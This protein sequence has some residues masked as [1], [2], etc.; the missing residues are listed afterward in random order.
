MR[1][2]RLG[3]ALVLTLPLTLTACGLLPEE[4]Q[5]PATPIIYDYKPQEYTQVEVLQGDLLDTTTVR[6]KYV[7]AKEETLSFSMGGA[8]LAQVYVNLGDQVQAGQLLAELEHTDL[9]TRIEAQEQKIQVLQVEKKHLLQ[10]REL[11][12]ARC[13]L[14]KKEED[15]LESLED[16]EKNYAG[17]LEDKEDAIYMQQLQL[18]ELKKDLQQRQIFASMDGTVTF[19]REMEAGERSVKGRGFLTISDMQTTVFTVEGKNAAYF[20]A[21]DTVQLNCK[22]KAYEAVVVEASDLGLEP[23]EEEIAYLR[24]TQPDPALEDG[25]TGTVEIVLEARQNVCYVEKKA[26][27][28]ADENTFVYMLDADG[29]RIMQPVTTGMQSG[30]YVEIVDGLEAGDWV[31]VK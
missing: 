5:L 14:I 10:D 11:A 8:Y 28:T 2:N 25:T 15:R 4:A 31:L 20:T 1:K 18:E 12:I 6:C 19:L 7:P 21:G 29:F 9:K 27:R 22:K 17:L 3:L 26:V 24:L 16:T 30:S 23:G 13:E